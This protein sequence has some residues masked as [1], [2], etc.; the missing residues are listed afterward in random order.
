M[1]GKFSIKLAPKTA[2]LGSSVC[3]ETLMLAP[4]IWKGMMTSRSKRPEALIE[5]A[6][7]PGPGGRY[8][9]RLS[10]PACEDRGQA[11]PS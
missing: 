11:G 4:G 1:D 3:F 5:T 9:E 7:P 6:L 2:A 10:S 8:P